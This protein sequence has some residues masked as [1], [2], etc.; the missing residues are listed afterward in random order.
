MTRWQLPE[1][2]GKVKAQIG[3]DWPEVTQHYRGINFIC[4]YRRSHTVVCTVPKYQMISS[5][6]LP[7]HP[8]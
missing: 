5:E 6:P 3:R 2:L 7:L 8:Q 4:T 1:E